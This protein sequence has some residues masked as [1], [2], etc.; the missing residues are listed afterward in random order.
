VKKFK[1]TPAAFEDI[2][3]IS[4]YTH[5]KWGIAKRNIYLTALENRFVWLSENPEIGKSRNEIKEGYFSYPEGKHV[6]FYRQKNNRIE[7]LAVLHQNMDFQ[8]HF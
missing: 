7:I 1:L 5:N 3:E 6:V 8:K 2:K 4:R